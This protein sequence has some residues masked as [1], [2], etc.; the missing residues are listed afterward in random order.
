MRRARRGLSLIDL[1]DITTQNRTKGSCTWPLR[2]SLTIQSRSGRGGTG[3]AEAVHKMECWMQSVPPAIHTR[4]D[5]GQWSAMPHQLKL[6]LQL[7]CFLRDLLTEYVQTSSMAPRFLCTRLRLS[8]SISVP[9]GR[10]SL[11]HTPLLARRSNAAL[12]L[13]RRHSRAAHKD[14]ARAA[15]AKPEPHAGAGPIG[16]TKRTMHP[17]RLS[18]RRSSPVNRGR[19]L[20]RSPLKRG[21]VTQGCAPLCAQ[22]WSA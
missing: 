14:L 12:A 17:R 13:L 16:K 18:Q 3:A 9:I 2:K 1:A 21:L 10:A 11:P 6:D 4:C 7:P 20:C 8:N 19:S 22:G 5:Y 15:R